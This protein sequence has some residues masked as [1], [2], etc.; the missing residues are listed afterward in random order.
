MADRAKK[1]AAAKKKV[2]STNPEESDVYDWVFTAESLSGKSSQS[3][4]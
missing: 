4:N 3:G 1:L 2:S